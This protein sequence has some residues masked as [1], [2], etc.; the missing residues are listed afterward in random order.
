MDAL[1]ALFNVELL[2]RKGEFVAARVAT[3]IP[4]LCALSA[5]RPRPSPVDAVSAELVEGISSAD[6]VDREADRELFKA[7]PWT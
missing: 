6:G 4:P 2:R 3:V 1:I 7:K 5:S